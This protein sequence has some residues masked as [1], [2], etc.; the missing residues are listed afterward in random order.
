MASGGQLPTYQ[1]YI[2]GVPVPPSRKTLKLRE[3][4][5]VLLVFVTFSTVCFGAFFFLPDLRDRVSVWEIRGLGQAGGDILVPPRQAAGGFVIDHHENEGID[6]HQVVDRERFAQN[7]K[8][9]AEK[10]IAEQIRGKL[11][12]SKLDHAQIQSEIDAE[13]ERLAKLKE[14]ADEKRREEE[15]RKA[16][17][18]IK[19][20]AEVAVIHRPGED[21]DENAQ[22]RETVKNVSLLALLCEG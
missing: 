4:Y 7:L 22:R 11:N 1:R 5:I 19:D 6:A 10:D 18:E 13:K 20:H 21:E 17:E 9:D 16:Q 15:L 8:W 14:F 12:M 3:K 2:S